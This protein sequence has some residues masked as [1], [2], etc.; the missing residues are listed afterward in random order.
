MKLCRTC[1]TNPTSSSRSVTCSDECRTALNKKHQKKYRDNNKE[2]QSKRN[3]IYHK[4]NPEE[5]K[6]RHYRIRYG[7][8]LEEAKQL[9]IS[10]GNC[11]AICNKQLDFY[12]GSKGRDKPVVDHCH[13]SKQVRGIL[14]TNCNLLLGYSLDKTTTLKTAI[15]YLEKYHQNTTT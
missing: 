13:T 10:Q 15:N 9:L 3:K 4:E 7:I 8:T 6:S 12:N 11:C 2:K 14:C 1:L 5:I